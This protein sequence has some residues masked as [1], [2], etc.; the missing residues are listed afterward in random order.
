MWETRYELLV[1]EVWAWSGSVRCGL[2]WSGGNWAG[3]AGQ[4]DNAGCTWHGAYG[5]ASEG[6]REREGDEW[7][8]EVGE[9]EGLAR[10][11][12]YY[13]DAEIVLV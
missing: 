6:E 13:L 10:E 2:E 1:L 3:A 12:G 11:S 4:A 9:E 5:F 8:G 7:T